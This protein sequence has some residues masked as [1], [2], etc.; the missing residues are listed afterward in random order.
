MSYSAH[1]RQFRRAAELYHSSIIRAVELSLCSKY[2]WV[3]LLLSQN[4]GTAVSV[5]QSLR[6]DLT[7]EFPC[8]LIF[9]NQGSY[10]PSAG[11]GNY[12]LQVQGVR[13]RSYICEAAC[14]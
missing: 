6:T 10:G 13:E 9:E 7:V 3:M 14:S 2:C 1:V 12:Y 8:L 5:G 11:H 4:C